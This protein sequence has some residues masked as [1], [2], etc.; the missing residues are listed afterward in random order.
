MHREQRSYDLDIGHTGNSSDT[1]DTLIDGYIT[2]EL[3]LC[4][5]ISLPWKIYHLWKL[6]LNKQIMGRIYVYLG[7]QSIK[8]VKE[9][10]HSI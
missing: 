7:Y 9:I 8:R 1:N 4:S 3:I 6:P 5:N 2:S 10:D